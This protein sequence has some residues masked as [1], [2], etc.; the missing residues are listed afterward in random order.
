M[1]VKNENK[2]NFSRKYKENFDSFINSRGPKSSNHQ[3]NKKFNY[4]RKSTKMHK[5]FLNTNDLNNV[6]LCPEPMI[7]GYYPNTKNRYQILANNCE[8]I[9]K[10]SINDNYQGGTGLLDSILREIAFNFAKSIK[11]YFDNFELNFPNTL[12]L[13]NPKSKLNF[14]EV[15][16]GLK[17]KNPTTAKLM[18]DSGCSHF[19]ISINV[20]NKIKDNCRY[21]LC[22]GETSLYTPSSAS[23]IILSGNSQ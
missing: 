16:L 10:D 4:R 6:S 11:N 1:D 22:E 13:P 8:F 3:N 18:V 12:R 15:E 9:N 7:P 5:E 14:V 20:F 21:V 2:S 17:T 19:C 23:I